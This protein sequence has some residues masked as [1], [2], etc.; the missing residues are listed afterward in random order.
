MTATFFTSLLVALPV[1]AGGILPDEWF[2]SSPVREQ[3]SILVGTL[4]LLLVWGAYRAMKFL[5]GVQAGSSN[6]SPHAMAPMELSPAMA[7]Y[8]LVKQVDQYCVVAA[9]LSMAEKGALAIN[10]QQGTYALSLTGAKGR[11][12]SP[13]ETALAKALFNGE[14]EIQLRTQ[15]YDRL[16]GE[17]PHVGDERWSSRV[18]L[19]DRL[20][21]A[22][23]RF[24]RALKHACSP[25]YVSH[26]AGAWAFGMLLSVGVVVLALL[27]EPT[28]DPG[29]AMFGRIATL[30]V[31][32]A[33]LA[34]AI[35]GGR[36]LWLGWRRHLVERSWRPLVSVEGI[37]VIVPACAALLWASLPHIQPALV[38]R[39]ASPCVPLLAL[40]LLGIGM[41]F[42][43]SLRTPTAEGRQISER[44]DSSQMFGAGSENAW[45]SAWQGRA[46]AKVPQDR[47]L[48]TGLARA[49]LHSSQL[50]GWGAPRMVY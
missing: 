13:D 2:D 6:T 39:F 17:I 44:L 8:L 29:Q 37:L 1:W 14:G 21:D 38:H 47:K 41:W 26:N 35:I 48:G 15:S 50:G 7:R 19:A 43:V 45:P 42:R 27:A 36:L 25:K 40:I 23:R 24:G 20:N 28:T 11:V 16:L 5:A 33:V 9:L 18:R 30:F 49:M 34:T 31:T 3:P 22:T 10:E 4:G 46:N 12:L 32:A